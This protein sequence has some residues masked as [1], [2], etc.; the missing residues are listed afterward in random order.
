MNKLFLLFVLISFI[1]C[2]PLHT[3]ERIDDYNLEESDKT[4][5]DLTVY[6]FQ[7]TGSLSRFRKFTRSYFDLSENTNL[8]DF[9]T[10]QIYPDTKMKVYIFNSEDV[11]S[12]LTLF[13]VS[14]KVQDSKKSKE[15]LRKEK[16]LNEAKAERRKNRN[17][18][19]YIHIQVMDEN[20]EDV[21]EKS[22]LYKNVVIKKLSDYR[23]Q[24]KKE[25]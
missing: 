12:K 17:T 21:F 3:A 7:Y 1:S 5:R 18:I 9:E 10:L 14:E 25:E 23:M 6:K 8:E 24:L 11:D 15:E 20:G 13:D 19:H 16:P 2:I 22:S 4:H